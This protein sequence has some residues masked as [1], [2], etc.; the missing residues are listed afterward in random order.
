[1]QLSPEVFQQLTGEPVPAAGFSVGSVSTS[2]ADAGG[3][4]GADRR[5]YGR[6]QLGRRAGVR[7]AGGPW[8]TVVIRDISVVGVGFL[9]DFPLPPGRPF[10]LRMTAAD[11]RA[12]CVECVVRRCEKGGVGGVA[13]FIGSTFHDGRD[14]DDAPAAITTGRPTVAS[15]FRRIGRR[16]RVR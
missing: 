3:P 14:D 1:M 9:S 2:V 15:V 6:V 16:L 10:T 8:Q 5:Q 11:D 13:F 12:V 7:F 4:G